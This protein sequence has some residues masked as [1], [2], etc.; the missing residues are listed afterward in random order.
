VKLI[1]LETED[2]LQAIAKVIGEDKEDVA[3][4]SQPVDQ[5]AG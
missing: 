1:E 2:K 5:P 4:D 3:G